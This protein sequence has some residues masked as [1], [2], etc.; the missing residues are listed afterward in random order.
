[1]AARIDK[2]ES[3]WVPAMPEAAKEVVFWCA[4][5]V[6]VV[7]GAVLI[8]HMDAVWRF[9]IPAAQSEAVVARR[10]ACRGEAREAG[11]P[12]AER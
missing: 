5:L 10:S 9:P 3:R 12:A 7:S 8:G 2:P 4:V 6:A 1:M 11:E